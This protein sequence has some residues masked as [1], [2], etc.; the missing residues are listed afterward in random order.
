MRQTG[1]LSIRGAGGHVKRSRDA[2]QG[3]DNF[4]QVD[5]VYLQSVDVGFVFGVP[6]VLGETERVDFHSAG[7][8]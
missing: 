2:P 1:V 3:R 8:Q 7:P 5:V 4:R 6:E